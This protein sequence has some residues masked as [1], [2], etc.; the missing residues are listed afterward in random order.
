MRDSL[1][2]SIAAVLRGTP[3][4]PAAH[5]SLDAAFAAVRSSADATEEGA[6]VTP[7]AADPATGAISP[8]PSATAGE[9]TAHRAA[10]AAD[11]A[12]RRGPFPP[13]SPSPSHPSGRPRH[14][15]L[16]GVAIAATIALA[17]AG[18]AY[19]ADR[20]GLID[21]RWSAPHQV[22]IGVSLDN[23]ASEAIPDTVEGYYTNLAY[24]P[25]GLSAKD[26]IGSEA[27]LDAAPSIQ[28][29]SSDF[30]EFL[31]V[32]TLYRDTNEALPL[33][34]A[35]ESEPVTVN[36]REALL[37][38]TRATA[39][40]E[41]LLQLIVPFEA[42]NRMVV[43]TAREP[44]RDEMLRVAEG[45][46]LTAAGPVPSDT[47]WLWSDYLRPDEPND[48][49]DPETG[50]HATA[51]QM[52][53]LHRI[54]ETVTLSNGTIGLTD[55]VPDNAPPILTARVTSVDT[56]DNL[57]SLACPELIPDD[58][59]ELVGDEGTLGP[60]T[61]IF[62]RWGDGESSLHEELE[63]RTI[64]VSLVSVTVEYTNTSS[65]VLD[66]FV[67]NAALLSAMESDTG[68]TVMRPEEAVTGADYAE[69]IAILSMGRTD[70]FDVDGANPS[71]NPDQ[72]NHIRNLGPGETA[73]VHFAWIVP[74]SET[75][76]LLLS[77]NGHGF[78]FSESSLALGYVD[79][80]Q[81]S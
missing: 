77:L 74:K 50:M 25:A 51:E 48:E 35:T 26:A 14:P 31:S 17:V 27:S 45:I 58:W 78:Q 1:D 11:A 38:T 15:W 41:G 56:A 2:A 39:E 72:P 64:P 5:H 43:V 54:G 60:D 53:N 63:R 67:F 9:T 33:S 47:L 81:E 20:L 24:K 42:E 29:F 75:S 80:R 69:S 70:Y 52:G 13:H 73:E 49:Y 40:S 21:L 30:M 10:T 55:L 66:D 7:C 23:T 12:A 4:S 19:G 46:S 65:A 44:F 79:L 57:S 61:V 62:T 3:A 76:H 59:M 32:Y 6:Q 18:T 37:V 36:D 16:R 28:F 22:M 8:R 71:D 34:F 68:W